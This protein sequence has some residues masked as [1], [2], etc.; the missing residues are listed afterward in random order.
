MEKKIVK[1]YADL[2]FQAKNATGRKEALSL[3]KQA[4]KLKNKFDHYEMM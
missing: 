2:I 4:T 3:I 1:K